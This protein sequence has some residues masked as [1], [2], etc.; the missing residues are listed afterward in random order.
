MLRNIEPVIALLALLASSALTAEKRTVDDS[1]P[2]PLAV[3]T[4]DFPD[5]TDAKRENR[6]LPIKVHIPKESGPFP[7][8]IL[9]HGGGGNRDAN[10]A[11]AHHLATHGFAVLCTEHPGSNTDVLKR[12]MQFAQ[13]LKA[14]TR[15]PSEV[16]GRSKDISFAIDR[17]EEWNTAHEKLR[18]RL[19]LKH[20]GVMGHSYGAYTTLVVLGAR[21]ALDWLPPSKDGVAQKGLALDLSDPRVACG[22]ALSPQGPGE[23]FFLETSYANLKRPLL[24]ITGSKDTQQG[25]P[26]ENRKRGFE[27]W[28]AGDKIFIWLDGAEHLAFSDPTGSGRPGFPSPTRDDAQ[29]VTRAATLLFFRAHLKQ[30][31]EALKALSTEN[32]KTYCRGKISGLE[33]LTK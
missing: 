30:D 19:D 27:L 9:S 18:G 4:I 12:G 14:M 5:L 20:I 2:G 25:F 15:D 24:G 32:L 29:P 8:V 3:E 31:A 7:V 21:P 26:P 6:R 16:L 1:V 28:P 13:N 33:V 17:A 11:Q 10:F 23:P 22:V